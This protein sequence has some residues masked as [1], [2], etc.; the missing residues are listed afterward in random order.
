LPIKIT[1]ENILFYEDISLKKR[2][3][4]LEEIEKRKI[5]RG[6]STICSFVELDVYVWQMSS[7]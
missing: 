2:C 4:S 5:T 7:T 3:S 1:F 6:L